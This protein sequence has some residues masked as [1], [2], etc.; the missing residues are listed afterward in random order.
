[1]YLVKLSGAGA[2]AGA[3]VVAGAKNS[4][5]RLRGAGAEK[6][7]FSAPQHCLYLWRRV[8]AAG[9][10]TVLRLLVVFPAHSSWCS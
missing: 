7:I 9:V 4:D 5:L 2:G 8:V 10:V 6:K 1:M 3:G